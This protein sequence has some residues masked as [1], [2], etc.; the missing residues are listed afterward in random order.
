M[1]TE[2]LTV[3][4][5]GDDG[6]EAADGTVVLTTTGLDLDGLGDYIAMIFRTVPIP[7]DATVNEARL[8]VYPPNSG[9]QSPDLTIAAELNPANLTTANSD[10]SDRTVGAASVNWI[11]TNI[12]INAYK[13]S[14]DIAA[15]IQEA[16]D[17]AGWTENDDLAIILAFRSG[18]SGWFQIQSANGANPPKLYLDWTPSGGSEEITYAWPGDYW[19]PLYWPEYWPDYGGGGSVGGSMVQIIMHHLGQMEIR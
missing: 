8:Q 14:P 16:V 1:T 15:V 12:G 17:D 3:T 2:V 5:G 9:R 6:A 4:A 19:P 7:A 13:D 11:A 18:G 10:I